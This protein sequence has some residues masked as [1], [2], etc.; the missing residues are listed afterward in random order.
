MTRTLPST[1]AVDATKPARV[2]R[3]L[4]VLDAAVTGVNGLAYLAAAGPLASLLGV[5][6]ELLRPIGVFL[7]G[8]GVAV[9]IVAARTN[10][11]RG[12]A[13]T[14][15]VANLLWAATSLLVVSIGALSATV[16]GSLWIAAQAVVVGAF[17]AAQGWALRRPA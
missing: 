13:L 6:A 8:Y 1:L 17:A 10:P 15:I 12:G 14:I 2:L 11:S 4:L 7:I 3:Q 16:I 9:A 5:P